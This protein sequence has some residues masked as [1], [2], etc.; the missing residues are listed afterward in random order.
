[1]M[2]SLGGIE[3]SLSW[4]LVWH[5]HQSTELDICISCRSDAECLQ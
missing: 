2:S 3:E 4:E 1:M 5:I